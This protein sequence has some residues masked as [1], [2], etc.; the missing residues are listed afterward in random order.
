MTQWS[1]K[2]LGERSAELCLDPTLEKLAS[3]AFNTA[4][5]FASYQQCQ[6][7]MSDEADRKLV[8][9]HGQV[10]LPD[11]YQGLTVRELG[12]K[13]FIKMKKHAQEFCL[14]FCNLQEILLDI[15]LEAAHT[16]IENRKIDNDENGTPDKAV[17][18]EDMEICLKVKNLGNSIKT[19]SRLEAQVD[20]DDMTM[21]SVFLMNV[22]RE[23][24][25]SGN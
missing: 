2:V 23:Q 7:F 4:K 6:K 15:D 8:P 1:S 9:T 25:S 5:W 16:A 18:T 12:E 13:L 11:E 24:G 14:S 21:A 19:F 20:D 17:P 10:K 3:Y 22:N